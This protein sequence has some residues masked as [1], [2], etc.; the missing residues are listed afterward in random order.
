M[1]VLRLGEGKRTTDKLRAGISPVVKFGAEG[2]G[3]MT[4]DRRG[5]VAAPPRLKLGGKIRARRR[6]RDLTLT[7]LANRTGLSVGFLS[8]VERD[9]TAPSLSSLALIASAL[10]ARIHDFIREP[11]PIQ[12]HHHDETGSAFAVD[13]GT[14]RYERLSGSFPGKQLNAIRM[15]VPPGYR[16][17][18]TSHDGE[19]FVFVLSGAIRYILSD[20]PVDLTTGDSLHFAARDRHRVENPRRS[21]AVLLTVVTQDLFGEKPSLPRRLRRGTL[22]VNA[23]LKPNV[24]RELPK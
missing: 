19:E 20:R 8:Q 18:E 13:E 12:L 6:D 22:S 3:G 14:L 4:G 24:P 7:D 17:E 15:D 23:S 2:T 10:D 21:P 1:R 9:I 5:I 16:S 11:P